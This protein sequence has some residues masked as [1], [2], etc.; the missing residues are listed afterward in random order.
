MGI[1]D[2]LR[3]DRNPF[4]SLTA[5]TKESVRSI[6]NVLSPDLLKPK[7]RQELR[8][9]DYYAITYGHCYVAAEVAYHLFAAEQGFVPYMAKDGESTHWWLV[10]EDTG[11]ILDPTYPQLEGNFE[12]YERGKRRAFLPQSPSRRAREVMRRLS[13]AP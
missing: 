13:D 1:F 2:F 12:V 9:E 3:Q 4:E 8:D 6:Q 7:Y 11:E 5:E 10:N